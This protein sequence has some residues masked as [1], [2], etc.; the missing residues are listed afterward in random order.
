M[1]SQFH[2]QLKQT[3]DYISAEILYLQWL[4][5]ACSKGK[6]ILQKAF[7]LISKQS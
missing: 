1:K 7:S 2:S 6:Q 4:S 5:S 3:Q